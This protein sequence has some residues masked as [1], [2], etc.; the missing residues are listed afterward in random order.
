MSGN[1]SWPS[2]RFVY[3][4]STIKVKMNVKVIC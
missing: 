1:P 3:K 4:F 2:K